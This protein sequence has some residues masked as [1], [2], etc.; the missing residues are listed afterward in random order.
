[1]RQIRQECP[2]FERK[3]PYKKLDFGDQPMSGGP[4]AHLD[5]RF[6]TAVTEEFSLIQ[7]GGSTGSM[8][9]HFRQHL[10]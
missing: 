8:M 2:T 7:V 6:P 9:K 4:G 5:S 10:F 3:K 1:L